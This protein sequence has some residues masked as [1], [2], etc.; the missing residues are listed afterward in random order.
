[1]KTKCLCMHSIIHVSLFTHVDTYVDTHT[2][3]KP[4]LHRQF[5]ILVPAST[6]DTYE[7][8][9]ITSRMRSRASRSRSLVELASSSG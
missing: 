4:K 6:D 7:I 2:Y 3:A 9:L 1:M 8:C 5:R